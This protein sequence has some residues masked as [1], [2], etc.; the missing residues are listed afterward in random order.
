MVTGIFVAPPPAATLTIK[1]IALVLNAVAHVTLGTGVLS[2]LLSYAV[3]KRRTP[4]ASP[5][6]ASVVSSSPPRLNASL[7]SCPAA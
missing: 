2:G 3:M 1:A 7:V 5:N 4:V 6:C